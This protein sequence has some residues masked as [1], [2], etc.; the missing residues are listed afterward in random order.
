MLTFERLLEDAGVD[1]ATCA[2]FRHTS[3]SRALNALLPSFVVERPELFASYQ[4][5]QG[6]GSAKMLRSATHLAA[7]IGQ[8]VGR[9]TYAGL[10][11]VGQGRPVTASECLSDPRQAQLAALGMHIAGDDEPA[12]TLFELEPTDIYAEWIGKLVIT[13]PS[14]GIN[15]RV[16]AHKHSFAIHAITEENRFK[17]PIPPWS[18]LAL[19]W[20]ELALL[21]P[22]WRHAL[23]QWR[24]VYFIFDEARGQGYVGSACGAEN[25]LQR[26]DEYAAT[27]HGGN[28]ALRASRPEDLRFSLLEEVA[29]AYPQP[30]AQRELDRR[31]VRAADTAASHVLTRRSRRP[32]SISYAS[33]PSR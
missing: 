6:P 29:S 11:R 19:S 2:V 7:F 27:G 9:A 3:P 31:E 13:W 1:L 17:K 33:T 24:G 32:S 23:A 14:R 12:D 30:W 21:P 5:V 4:S 8:D 25:V 16:R 22:S 26:W 18:E 28:I 10:W 20:S 15:W